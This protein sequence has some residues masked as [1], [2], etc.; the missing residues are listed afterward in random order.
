MAEVTGLTG[1]RPVGDNIKKITCPPYDVIKPGSQLEAL[2]QQNEDSLYHITL[3]KEPE[4]ALERLR[5][6]GRLQ[7]EETPCFYVYEQVYG[8][9]IRRGVFAAVA[10]VDYQEG[11]II[12]HEKT[13]DDKVKGRLKLREKTG[14]TFEPVFLLTQASLRAVL[15]E[16]ISKYQAVA[17]FVSDFKQASELH[18]IKNRIF[19]VE[20]KSREGQLIK[21]VIASKPLYIADGHHRYHASL[22]NR[23]T[24]C[25]AY[26]CEDTDARILAYNRVINGLVKFAQIKEKLPLTKVE[27]FKTP[28]KHSFAIYTKE[29]TYLLKAQHIPE[30]VVGCLDCSVLEKELYPYLG[31]TREMITDSF[32]FDYYAENELEK[33]KKCVDSGQYDLAV[34]L[35]PVSV[36]ELIAV[37]DAGINNPDIVM[38]EKSTF[39]APKILSGIFIYKHRKVI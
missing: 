17:E 25:L 32:Y 16:I 14:Y 29:G 3:G 22:Y 20:E 11:Q 2:L 4:K 39:F 8:Q 30:D 12:R 19:R 37:A 6:E 27:E 26:L 34:A 36:G 23:Q 9:E 18:G 21:E 1:L 31:L 38:P 33:M 35:A 10:V 28:E 7:E 24:H 13:F 15:D 5:E